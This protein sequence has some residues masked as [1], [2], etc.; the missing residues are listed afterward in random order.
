MSELEHTDPGGINNT[1]SQKATCAALVH[2]CAVAYR[3]RWFLE[4]ARSDPWH[5]NIVLQLA[6]SVGDEIDSLCSYIDM[7]LALFPLL[8]QHAS[9]EHGGGYT[10]SDQLSG[11][12][13]KYFSWF[14]ELGALECHRSVR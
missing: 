3:G 10:I 5:A 12:Q 11:T 2:K 8:L 14:N 13:A 7:L 9:F 4:R 1:W 6:E